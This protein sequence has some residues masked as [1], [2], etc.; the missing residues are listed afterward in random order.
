LF[1]GVFQ[2]LESCKIDQLK[3]EHKQILM[4]LRLDYSQLTDDTLLYCDNTLPSTEY[5]LEQ[6]RKSDSLD[7]NE[8]RRMSE[9]LNPNQLIDRCN[10]L[11]KAIIGLND[12]IKND[13]YYKTTGLKSYLRT[14][15]GGALCV[16]SIVLV[17]VMP[18]ALPLEIGI[19]A[20]TALIFAGTIPSTIQFFKGLTAAQLEK[21]I[22][23]LSEKLTEAKTHVGNITNKLSDIRLNHNNAYIRL[24]KDDVEDLTRF[25]ESMTQSIKELRT[26]CQNAVKD[27]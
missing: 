22:V 27:F 11:R 5:I 15:M 16:A 6:L 4:K 1:S 18:W 7:L 26:L 21:D 3:D 12:Q 25:Y 19:V 23:Q 8:L 2:E 13:N 24:E 20:S 17:F 14:M 9:Q 10:T